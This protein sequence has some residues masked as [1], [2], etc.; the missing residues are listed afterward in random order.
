MR[1]L[2]N[3]LPMKTI[4]FKGDEKLFEE[5]KDEQLWGNDTEGGMGWK[6]MKNKTNFFIHFSSNFFL[7][8]KF[9]CSFFC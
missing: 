6:R 4:N 1:R 7:N 9:F 5:E 8:Y 2:F 3:I